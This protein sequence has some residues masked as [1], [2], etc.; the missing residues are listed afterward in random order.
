LNNGQSS[1]ET[2]SHAEFYKAKLIGG[3]ASVGAGGDAL[4]VNGF[5]TEAVIYGGEF[6]GGT[7]VASM[8]YSVKVMNSAS[9]HIHGGTFVG[10]MM[11]EGGAAILLHGCFS[12]SNNETQVSGLFAD[13]TEISVAVKKEGNGYIDFVSMPG[14]E[15]DTAP[16]FY[17]TSFSTL[18][19]QPTFVQKNGERR[20][21][22]STSVIMLCLIT[23][24]QSFL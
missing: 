8:G 22:T 20:L 23:L 15:C 24:L 6:V 14:Q 9:V 1:P 17:P 13:E 4:V 2:A 3:D 11:V 16:S 10:G 19:P 12:T 5:G 21:I 18:S 7:G